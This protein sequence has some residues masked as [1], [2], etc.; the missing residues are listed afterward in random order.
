MITLTKRETDGVKLKDRAKIM[1]KRIL[2]RCIAGDGLPVNR[3][4]MHHTLYSKELQY[5]EKRGLIKRKRVH[6]GLNS[7]LTMMVVVK[8]FK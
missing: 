5:L 3:E 7:R 8:K 6:R 1:Y 4:G 2:E